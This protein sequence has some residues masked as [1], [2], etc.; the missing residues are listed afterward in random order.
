MS[1]VDGSSRLSGLD[2]E[3]LKQLVDE[4]VADAYREHGYVKV[5]DEGEEA[6]DKG[7]LHEAIYNALKRAVISDSKSRSEKA[8][9]H[10]DLAK[11]VFPKTPGANDEWDQLDP[12]QRG[13]WE[14]VVKDA[15]NP[16]NPNYSGPVQRLVGERDDKLVLIK[17]KTTVAGTPGVD[18]VY[19]TA[20]EEL[21]FDDFIAPLKSSVRRAAERLAKNA[22]LVSTRNKELATKAGR[23]VDSGMKA[24]AQ[25][26]KS[27]LELM[28]GTNES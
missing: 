16:T 11:R 4:G 22:A 21:I 14:Q 24:A 18:V 17:T 6:L 9:T 1:T 15:W 2:D 25:L 8:L 19:L 12:V 26:A 5:N 13:V 27:T 28:S 10:G 20:S 23:E 7:A 3:T